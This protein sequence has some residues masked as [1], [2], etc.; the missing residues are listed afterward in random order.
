MLPLWLRRELVETPGEVLLRRTADGVLLTAVAPDGD[1]EQAAD[2][3][4][5]LRLGRRVTNDEVTE[6]VRDERSGR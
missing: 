1:V 6:A 3:M 5:V 2:G 4:P